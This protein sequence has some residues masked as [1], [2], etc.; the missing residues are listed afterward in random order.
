MFGGGELSPFLRCPNV[1]FLFL[2]LLEVPLLDSNFVRLSMDVVCR[3]FLSCLS[4][5][6]IVHNLCSF[7]AVVAVS[8][9]TA[10]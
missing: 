6:I 5:C 2:T 10:F 7:D 8:V 1:V 3:R 9:S 4:T